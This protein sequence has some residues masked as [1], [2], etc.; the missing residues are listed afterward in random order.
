MKYRYRNFCFFI[1]L[2]ALL[3]GITGCLK[4]AHAPSGNGLSHA[5]SSSAVLFLAQA[6]FRTEQQPDGEA[7]SI[8]GAAK[9]TM[10]KRTPDGWKSTLLEDPESNVFHKALWFNP[11]SG[12]PGI[13]TISG[14][15][16]A[17]K[18]WHR[19]EAGQWKGTLLWNPTFG[20]EQNRLRD[21]ETGDVTGD[22][23]DDLVIAT[24]DQG[25]V[26]VLQWKDG[27]WV[28]TE[29]GR[30]P[31]TFV[32]EIEIGDINH[33]GKKEFF[34]TPS[35][36]NR[37]DGSPQPGK[38]IMYRFDG[39]RFL[40]DI[41]EEFP[42][43][44]VKEILAA[45]VTGSGYPDLFAA[46]EGEM[47]TVQGQPGLVDTAKIKQ[48]RFVNGQ[49]SGQII[50]DLPDML[51]R[52]LTA[53]DVDGDGSID[54]VASTMQSGIWVLRQKEQG[55][56][57]KSLID[58]QSSGFEHA[59]LISDLDHDGKNEI[60]VASDDQHFLRQYQWNGKTFVR[61][62]LIPLQPDDITFGLTLGW[63]PK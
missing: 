6:Q 61:N 8:P 60:Y 54:I 17:L 62:D 26:A 2:A 20:G 30:T 11:P 32:H 28:I 35:A 33:D 48:Y 38:I 9:L 47:G 56:W 53:A 34:S 23:G 50:A 63:M 12:Q 39:E 37:L 55:N 52:Y 31:D 19:N 4:A 41:V 18:L 29:L 22:G 44:H 27:A 42:N 5:A 59:T 7:R 40:S 45:D 13:L 43:R 51:C 1:L 36:P 10:V 15:A 16:A 58:D 49:L 57:E 14:N 21:V 25:I 3:G 46:I 24:H